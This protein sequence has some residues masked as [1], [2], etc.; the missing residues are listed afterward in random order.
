MSA[1]ALSTLIRRDAAEV[2]RYCSDLRNELRWNPDLLSVEKLSD[3]PIGVGTRFRA[4]WRNTKPTLVEVVAF[5]PGHRWSTIAHAFQ[6]EI[7]SSGTVEAAAE[8]ARFTAELAVRGTGL[9]RLIAPFAVRAM[10]RQDIRNMRLI[11]EALEVGTAAR[12]IETAATESAGWRT[13]SRRAKAF[14]IAHVLA[15]VVNMS[16]LGYI[17]LSAVQRRRDPKLLASVGV[18]SAEGLALV[19]GRGNCPFGPF[20]RSLGDPVPMFELFLQ[21]RAAKAAIP[22]LTVVALAGFLAVFIRRPRQPDPAMPSDD[23]Q[24]GAGE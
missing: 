23:P 5:E 8:G 6:M 13:L 22:V 19:I 20:Q 1:Y 9:G 7:R 24:R 10:R 16:A 12:S 15:G 11:R 18:L 14:R 3:G 2:A 21:P 17:W 4:Q